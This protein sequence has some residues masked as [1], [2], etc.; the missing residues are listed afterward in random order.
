MAGIKDLKVGDQVQLV[1]LKASAPPSFE[2]YLKDVGEIVGTGFDMVRVS[3]QG[4]ELVV[5]PYEVDLISPDWWDIWKVE[6]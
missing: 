1:R 6:D 4:C 5:Y 2:N 3:F